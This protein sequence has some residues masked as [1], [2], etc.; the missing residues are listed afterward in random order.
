MRFDE[1]SVVAAAAAPILSL[2]IHIFMTTDFAECW[3]SLRATSITACRRVSS[4]RFQWV[5]ERR[6]VEEVFGF[7]F[8]NVVIF[9]DADAIEQRAS[10]V[11]AV[12][13]EPS[14]SA[15]WSRTE[16]NA[17]K[18]ALRKQQSRSRLDQTAN[19]RAQAMESGGSPLG[20]RG[21][22]PP[23]GRSC[24][25]IMSHIHLPRLHRSRGSSES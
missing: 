14:L 16:R 2:L 22:S 13:A 4:M 24:H 20:G 6:A 5:G 10:G 21:G 1:L 12:A 23:G 7:K 18:K 9:T 8:T 19:A 17:K 25:S 15:A 11:P 3:R